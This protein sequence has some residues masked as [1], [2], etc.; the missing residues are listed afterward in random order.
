MG[1]ILGKPLGILLFSWLA[2]RLG[3]AELPDNVRFV[4][5]LGA[6]I[7]CGIG[8]TVTLFVTSLAFSNE[9]LVAEGKVAILSAALVAGVAGYV[10][11]WIAPG[12]PDAEP[13]SREQGPHVSVPGA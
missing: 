2:I 12:E 11:L 5:I 7:L 8:F 4:H 6:G 9:A 10:Y 1:L 3:I 13:G